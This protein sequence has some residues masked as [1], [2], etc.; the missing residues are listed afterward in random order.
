MTWEGLRA[1]ILETNDTGPV[2]IDVL[3]ILVGVDSGCVIPMGAAGSEGLL[4]RLQR[5]PG[6]DS[7]AVIRASSSVE[8]RQFLCWE[9]PSP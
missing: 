3:W 1:V 6:F 4:G 8:N 5:L 7:E 2:G 9:R